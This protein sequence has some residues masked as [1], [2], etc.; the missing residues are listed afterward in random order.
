MC[1]KFLPNNR[2]SS[3]NLPRSW[4]SKQKKNTASNVESELRRE[5]KGAQKKIF[6]FPLSSFNFRYTIKFLH[7]VVALYTLYFSVSLVQIFLLSISLTNRSEVFSVLRAF[8]DPSA[9][10]EFQCLKESTN[11]ETHDVFSG[12]YL[13]IHSRKNILKKFDF[14]YKKKLF[15]EK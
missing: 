10:G 15:L 2:L 7:S 14:L 13:F 3:M 1:L 11:I 12:N 6:F 9:S 5:K 4:E 8:V